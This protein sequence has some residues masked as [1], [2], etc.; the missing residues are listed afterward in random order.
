MII[1]CVFVKNSAL[2]WEEREVT[3]KQTGVLLRVLLVA[4]VALVLVLFV[5]DSYSL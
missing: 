1:G 3:K 4:T 2:S 5:N